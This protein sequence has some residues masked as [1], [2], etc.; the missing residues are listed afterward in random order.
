MMF[1]KALKEHDEAL[2]VVRWLREDIMGVIAERQGGEFVDLTKIQDAGSKLKAY[3]HLF[4]Q[5]AM[6]EFN[7]L[8]QNE[9]QAVDPE[10]L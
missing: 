3:A 2:Q 9:A 5:K 7:Q 1:I 8:T 6:D 4:D 10:S